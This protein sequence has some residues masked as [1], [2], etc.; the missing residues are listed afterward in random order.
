MSTAERV[1]AESAIA[2]ASIVM[3][4]GS[5]WTDSEILQTFT[6][7]EPAADRALES[8]HARHGVEIAAF[9]VKAHIRR[10]LLN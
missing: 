3:L 4:R 8:Y 6:L 2:E 9:R 5:G 10:M 1:I 7:P